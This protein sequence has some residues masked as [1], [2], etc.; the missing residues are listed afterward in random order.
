MPEISAKKEDPAIVSK[1]CRFAVHINPPK[2]GSS[3]QDLHFIKE[4]ITYADGTQKPNVVLDYDYRRPYY[5]TKKGMRNYSEFKEWET[6]EHLDEYFCTQSTLTES[7]ARSLGQPYFRGGLRDL[8]TSPYIYGV[9]M[10]STSLIKADYR[11]RYPNA[12]T[13]FTLAA[14]DTETDVIHGHG[15]ILIAGL[16]FKDKI[17]VAI[18]SSFLEGYSNV[19]PRLHETTQRYLGEILEKRGAKVEFELFPTEIDVVRGVIAKAHQWSPDWLAVWNVEF[20]MDKIIQAC[21]RAHVEVADLLSDPI[22]PKEYRF[23]KFK[24]GPA[25]KVMASGR[26]LNFKPSQRWHSVFCPSSFYWIDAM[27][28]YRQ[29]RQGAPEDPS[30][31]LDAILKKHKL[32]GKLK[33]EG[34]AHVEHDPLGWHKLMQSK[35]PFEYVVYNIY[36]CVGMELLD[37]KTKDLQMALPNFAGC[38]DFNNFP[39]LPKKTMN[40]LHFFI[41]ERGRVPGSTASEMSTDNDGLTQELTGWITMLP[42]HLVEDNGLKCI[43]E[44]PHLSTNI[45]IAVADLDITGAYPT[46]EDCCNVS[47]E[48]TRKEII[49][50]EGCDDLT[51]RYQTLGFSG[52]KANAVE[53]AIVMYKLPQLDTLLSAFQQHLST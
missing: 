29:V 17:Y 50:V 1:E 46:N 42:S 10:S 32:G 31:A 26:I 4:V 11:K 38:T 6:R 21:D 9:D 53:W 18:Q 20:D 24:K 49:K 37:E 47:K 5:L 35:F 27:C 23:F 48:T 15:Q 14:F 28:A 2:A 33:F 8:C 3:T 34:A 12:I 52:G 51:T 7:V 39:S 43:L 45:R 16:T 13:P 36:D 22:V 19:M 40:D 41:G 30:Y 44:H 25:K